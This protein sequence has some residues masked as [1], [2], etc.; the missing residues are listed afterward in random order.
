MNR[1][2]YML[3]ENIKSIFILPRPTNIRQLKSNFAYYF[4]TIVLKKK[5]TSQ[6]QD[7]IINANFYGQELD[8][9]WQKLSEI[10]QT[11]QSTIC[12]EDWRKPV[13]NTKIP[14]ATESGRH[15]PRT[16]KKHLAVYSTQL[17]RARQT[18]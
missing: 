2:E 12:S 6:S 18:H 15:L 8:Y 9:Q 1:S 16:S 14:A 11:Y 13:K 17:H 7:T 4:M 5:K 3:L 10:R